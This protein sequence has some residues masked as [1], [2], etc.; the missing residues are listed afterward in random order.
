MRDNPRAENPVRLMETYTAP[1]K[2]NLPAPNMEAPTT[3]T[4][5]SG[6]E[7][8]QATNAG[9]TTNAGLPIVARNFSIYTA[10]YKEMPLM[11]RPY[12]HQYKFLVKDF[13][14]HFLNK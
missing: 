9:Q 12:T 10:S 13:C 1:K 2:G 6:E 5:S 7:E 14:I 4:T 11:H 3:T 8:G